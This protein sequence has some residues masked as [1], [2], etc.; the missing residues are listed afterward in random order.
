MA[1]TVAKVSTNNFNYW[2]LYFEEF[3]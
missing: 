1:A 2:N 3:I